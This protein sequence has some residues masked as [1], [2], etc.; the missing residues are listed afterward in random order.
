MHLL[1]ADESAMNNA[2][3]TTA[4]LTLYDVTSGKL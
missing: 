2:F 4:N 3:E 1:E